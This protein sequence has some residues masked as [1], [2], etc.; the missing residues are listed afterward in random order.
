MDLQT[1][2]WKSLEVSYWVI[3]VD[4]EQPRGFYEEKRTVLI[5]GIEV[6]R[7]K[8]VFFVAEVK[9]YFQ[10]AGKD[11]SRLILDNGKIWNIRLYG[12]RDLIICDDFDNS[13]SSS[14]T[15]SDF[16]FYNAIKE[17]CLKN[18]K[19]RF[20]NIERSNIRVCSNPTLDGKLIP[21]NRCSCPS[22]SLPL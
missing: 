6:D 10:G 16:S 14:I 4:E 8:S 3:H 1:T 20:N 21:Y 18:E 2:K 19:I 22:H 7:L 15:L 9:D 12:Q 17:L 13:Y 5:E 11:A